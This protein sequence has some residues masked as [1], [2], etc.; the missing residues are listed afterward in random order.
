MVHEQW[1][2]QTESSQAGR[3]LAFYPLRSGREIT[4]ADAIQ[5]LQEDPPFRSALIQVI[6]DCP[7]T[8]LR[9]ET[10]QVTTKT[11]QRR[12]EFVLLD[13]PYLD[14]PANQRDFQEYFESAGSTQAVA[15]LNLGGDGIMIAPCPLSDASCYSHLAAF[16][17]FAAEPQQHEFWQLVGSTLQQRVSE[18]PV[19]LSTAGGG[20]DWLHVRLDDRPKYYGH[21]PFR[22]E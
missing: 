22:T 19:W 1:S 5:A 6:A 8:A 17:R 12:F 10:P 14:V 7:F 2:W 16:S 11:L 20:V 4:F 13:S 18:K 21:A 9:W 3:V 15:F